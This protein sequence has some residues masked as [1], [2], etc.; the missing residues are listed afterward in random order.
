MTFS[1]KNFVR[2]TVERAVSTAA[3][4]ALAV[5]AVAAPMDITTAA[6]WVAVASTAAL[7]GFVSVLK[8]LAASK[9]GSDDSASLVALHP[10]SPRTVNVFV[11][12]DG[13]SP[14]NYVS[15]Q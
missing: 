3:E 10:D 1:A 8:S 7:A 12:G 6:Y 5:A 14:E 11:K 15:Q 4:A 2:D 9:W 13:R